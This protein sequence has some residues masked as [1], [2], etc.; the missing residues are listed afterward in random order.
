MRLSL[1]V[2]AMSLAHP[3]WANPCREQKGYFRRAI[4]FF[5]E[6][7]SPPT[8]ASRASRAPSPSNEPQL[9]IWEMM[10][11]GR[12]SE[13]QALRTQLETALKSEPVVAI[14]ELGGGITPSYII[15]LKNGMRAV[16]KP[17]A[18]DFA[19]SKAEVAAYEL[20]KILGLERVPV[21]TERIVESAPGSVQFYLE[22]TMDGKMFHEILGRDFRELP[23]SERQNLMFFDFLTANGDRNPGNYLIQKGANQSS[24][25]V[26]IDHGRL[27]EYSGPLNSSQ[28]LPTQVIPS[29][30]LYDRLVGLD[31]SGF[32]AQMQK[33]M[34]SEQITAFLGRRDFLIRQIEKMRAQYGDAR[35]FPADK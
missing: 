27:F 19:N 13:A 4:E 3:A 6:R 11:Q 21:T 28:R 8:G 18:S 12:P 29:R 5:T 20:S 33:F 2:L 30:S 14:E 24:R 10:D 1:I 31:V 34:T 32:K 15:T 22:Q 26:A 17:N 16:Y 23:L 9:K 7:K 35:V 25:V